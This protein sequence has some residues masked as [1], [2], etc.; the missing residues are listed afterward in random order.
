M[1]LPMQLWIVVYVGSW[2][3]YRHD[4]AL[5]EVIDVCRAVIFC[6]QRGFSV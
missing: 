5:A 2:L 3:V 4:G 6:G 1:L